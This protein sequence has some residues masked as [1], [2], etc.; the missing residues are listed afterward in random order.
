[1]I[2]PLSV[3][4][5]T[6]AAILVIAGA[7][8]TRPAA[9]EIDKDAALTAI[10]RH[11]CE[12]SYKLTGQVRRAVMTR[13]GDLAYVWIEGLLLDYT[14]IGSGDVL[15][16]LFLVYSREGEV[17]SFGRQHFPAGPDESDD[18]IS[19][20]K[21][22]LAG[23]QEK[24]QFVEPTDCRRR[25]VDTPMKW[26]LLKAIEHTMVYELSEFNRNGVAHYPRRVKIIVENFNFNDSGTD[27]M[28]AVDRSVW[29]VHFHWEDDPLH[30][31]YG[32]N[33]I[34]RQHFGDRAKSVR[35]RIRK[36]GGLIRYI[37]LH[38]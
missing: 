36:Q 15:S 12:A 20:E 14:W 30:D 32:K 2:I 21:K 24:I 31:I 11:L 38:D 33:W 25:F 22:F 9:A 8:L 4:R 5:S 27:L 10:Q 1:M 29:S 28:V 19:V 6:F 34:P 18:V 3:M 13:D 37:E 35:D 26:Q 16:D 23:P 7:A 17:A